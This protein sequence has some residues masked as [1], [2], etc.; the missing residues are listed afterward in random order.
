VPA[1]AE[2]RGTEETPS[3]L[4]ATGSTGSIALEV[5]SSSG[6]SAEEARSE[7]GTRFSVG[8]G[9]KQVE[10]EAFA[11]APGSPRISEGEETG[12]DCASTLK[13]FAPASSSS[14]S[15]LD[16]RNVSNLKS[17]K[18]MGRTNYLKSAAGDGEELRSILETSFFLLPAGNKTIELGLL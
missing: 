5:S 17:K 15:Q 7:P 1:A 8:S 9:G 13:S 2:P 14:S 3:K 10:P 16:H 4:A 12:S 11:T 6:L 18:N